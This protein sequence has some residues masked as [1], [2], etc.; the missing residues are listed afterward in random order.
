MKTQTAR[1]IS[2]FESH[3]GRQYFIAEADNGEII[4]VLVHV[5][6]CTS[7]SVSY[8]DTISYVY[9]GGRAYFVAQADL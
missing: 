4:D 2:Q 1:V 9:L 5:R 8:G 3:H 6:Q 7:A